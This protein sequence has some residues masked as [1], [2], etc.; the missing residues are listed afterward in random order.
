MFTPDIT[1]AALRAM[2][3]RYGERIYGH[4]G[5]ADA[6]NPNTGWVGPDVIGIDVGITLL[7]A[8][9][10]RTGNVWRWFMRNREI[11]RALELVGMKRSAGR[12]RAVRKRAV[13]S[14]ALMKLV[15]QPAGQEALI[16][17][18]RILS[19]GGALYQ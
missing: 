8:E 6:F 9:N 4:Y 12:R 19:P 2:R 10:L 1:L 16:T 15:S 11:T 3:E 14:R 5:F 17:G 13:T 7:S 18:G